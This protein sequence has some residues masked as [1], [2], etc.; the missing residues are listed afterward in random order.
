MS[1]TKKIPAKAPARK[2]LAAPIDQNYGILAV[3]GMPTRVWHSA[4][5][6]L[7]LEKQ[8]EFARFDSGMSVDCLPGET[9]Q[10]ALARCQ[11]VVHED[12]REQAMTILGVGSAASKKRKS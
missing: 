5:L 11:E 12:V 1:A 3:P 4:G 6:T 9:P 10:D 8:Y 7:G 2:L